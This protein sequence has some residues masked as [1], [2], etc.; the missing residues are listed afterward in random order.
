[1]QKRKIHF[2]NL[3]LYFGLSTTLLI[4]YFLGEDSSGS[5]GF[6][7]D[8]NSTWPVLKLIEKGEYFN[9]LEYTI[10]FPLHYYILYFFNLLVE[11]KDAVRLLFTLI[12]L[13]TP[14]IFFLILK[15]KFLKTDLNKLFFL[16][17]II[18]LLLSFRSGAIWANTQLT[19]LLFFMISIFY[20]LKWENQRSKLIDK[21]L[22]LQCFFLSLAVYSRQLYAIV[23]I[24]IVYIYFL[25]LDFKEF[26]KSSILIFI[27][28]L[29]GIFI[30]LSVPRT[31][32]L[33]FDFNLAN[34]LIVNTSIISFYL[35]PLYFVI[36]LNY[37]QDYKKFNITKEHYSLILL[38][39]LLVLLSSTV[40]N[41]NPS[42]GGGFFIKLSMIVFNNLYFFF[43]TS[44]IGIILIMLIFKENKNTLIL[45][46]LLI[47]GFSSYQI[48][49]KYFEPMLIILLFSIIEFSQI[50]LIFK[51]YKNIIL[52]QSYFIVYLISAIINDILQITKTFF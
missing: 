38:S 25:K 26:I 43:V 2:L 16:S 19:A 32:S 1:M 22:V 36:G 11:S 51:N 30:V 7:V 20:F 50:K 39:F 31:L 49:Q 9:F 44:F 23:F 28:S 18:F 34:S 41:Y 37:L 5:G 48:F 35:I 21:N 46:L 29:P 15:E 40:F 12:S 17:Q 24:Y 42:L 4:G 13:I 6:P 27:F 3:V 47:F 45:F 33:T 14:Y 8:F 10:H 52:F